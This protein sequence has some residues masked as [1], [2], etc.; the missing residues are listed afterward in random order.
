MNRGPIFVGG[1]NRSGTSLMYAL[2]ASHPNISMVQRTDM[3]RF[4]YKR[5]GDLRQPENFERC[6]DAML[7]YRRIRRLEPDPERIRQEFW[8]G[9]P[10]YGR[11]FA[12][13]H[14]HYAE[15]MGKPRWGDKSLHTEQHAEQIFTEFPAA[16]LIH[17]V[18]DPRDRY[19]SERK[20]YQASAATATG[21]WLSSVHAA[22]RNLQRYP[23][24]YMVVRYEDL[25]REPA[26]TLRRVCDFLDETYTPAMLTMTGAPEHLAQGGDS[27]FEQFAPGEISTRS[28]GRFRSAL[29]EQDTAFIQ[30]CA[31]REMT[32]FDY[33]LEPVAFSPRK[34]WL[35]HLMTLPA[36]RIRLARWFMVNKWRDAKG[37][38]IPARRVVDEPAVQQLRE[39]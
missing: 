9:E 38:T 26:G 39:A 17:V 25:A 12:L 29:S 21:K 10:T 1:S 4:F 8:Q 35:F 36:G 20:K 15:R 2:L 27:S 19:A 31:G 5:Y 23:E 13:F 28:I 30:A 34:R 11:L 24:G 3:W 6:L 14:A 18:R 33:P 32:E 37:R 7:Q 16:R 22:E